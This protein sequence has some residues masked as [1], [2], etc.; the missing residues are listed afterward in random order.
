LTLPSFLV[1]GAGRCGTT[2]L[3]DYLGQHPQ[4]FM[5]RIKE[6]RYFIFMD[7]P[8]VVPDPSSDWIRRHAVNRRA[9]YEALF[10]DAG[11]ARAMGEVSPAYLTTPE[12]PARIR[13]LIPAARLVAILR[14]P[15]ERA[16]SSWLGRRRDGA[17]S[18]PTFE[19]WLADDPKR[20]REGWLS[21]GLLE[22]SRYATHLK[23]FREHFP[24]Q[25][26]RVFL[27]DD[28]VADSL[29]L[30][31]D[32][33]AFL[34]VDPLFVPD[35]SR[36]GGRTGLVRNPMLRLFWTNSAQ[37]RR[38]IRPMVPERLRD[39]AFERLT[40]D[41]VKPPL[42]PETRAR[43]TAAVRDEILEL[44]DLIGRDLSHWLR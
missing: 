8:V 18:T 26:T 38:V 16:H 28:L 4:V 19:Q 14:Q 25:Q 36:R 24:R 20:V 6:P 23:R 43:F 29:A 41:L 1:I 32:L 44:Q 30:M 15:A 42:D 10:A 2:S 7:R 34:D 3:H 12:V 11:D 17:E 5:S 33:Y 22:K 21:A 37:I 9:D 39:R 40:R 31:R 13:S 27:Y 35:L